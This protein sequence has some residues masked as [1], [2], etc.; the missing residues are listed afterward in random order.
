[1]AAGGLA[2]WHLDNASWPADNPGWMSDPSKASCADGG[3]HYFVLRV[4]LD[5]VRPPVWRRFVV[6]ASITLDLLHDVL[7][8]VMGWEDYHLHEFTIGGTHYTEG[9]EELYD[10]HNEKGLDENGVVLSMLVDTPKAKFTYLYDFGDGWRHTVTVEKIEPI[11]AGHGVRLVCLAGKR[12]CPP[13]DVGG[14]FGYGE[15]LHALA[16]PEHDEHQAML[17]WRGEFDPTDFYTEDVNAELA[18]L[19]RWSPAP[20]ETASRRHRPV[21]HRPLSQ[22]LPV[23]C[24]NELGRRGAR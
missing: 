9:P 24:E 11:P 20:K 19:I 10:G 13:E 1:M 23:S 18:K 4:A 6:P 15:Y 5:E 14:P 3:G 8:V 21:V 22:L 2:R 17:D 12:R 16:D 7:Q